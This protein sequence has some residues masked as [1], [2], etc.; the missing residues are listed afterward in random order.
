MAALHARSRLTRLITAVLSEMLYWLGI[1][2]IYKVL[3]RLCCC[4]VASV[5]PSIKCV[6]WCVDISNA[7]VVS[8]DVCTP[9]NTS[10]V[11]DKGGFRTMFT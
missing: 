7:R 3:T 5:L 9:Y 8:F 1:G 6:A 11:C 10:R 4:I 2:L